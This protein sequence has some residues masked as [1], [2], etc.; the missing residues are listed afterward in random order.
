M[1]I[2]P[3][4]EDFRFVLEVTRIYTTW[5]NRIEIRSPEYVLRPVS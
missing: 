4:G 5:S 3:Y 2:T 1:T